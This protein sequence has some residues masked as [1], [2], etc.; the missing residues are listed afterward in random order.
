MAFDMLMLMD[1][2]RELYLNG[3]YR[4]LDPSRNRSPSTHPYNFDPYWVWDHRSN[5]DATR[6]EAIYSD[7]LVQHDFTKYKEAFEVVREKFGLDRSQWLEQMTPEQVTVFLNH[8][9]DRDN[10][11]AVALARGCNQS[12]GNPYVIIWSIWPQQGEQK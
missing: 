1:E 5:L 7:R 3:G 9:F 8:F 6:T 2:E 12:N 11:R 10:L 4:F